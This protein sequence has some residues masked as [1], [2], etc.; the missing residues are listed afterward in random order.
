MTREG[1]EAVR[2]TVFRQIRRSPQERQDDETC[3]LRGLFAK[4]V[5]AI[6]SLQLAEARRTGARSLI[7]KTTQPK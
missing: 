4:E 1:V 2:R 5:Y 3:I 6:L 7:R